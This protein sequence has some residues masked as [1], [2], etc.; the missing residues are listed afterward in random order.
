[1]G[2]DDK[3]KH[4]VKDAEGKVKEAMGKMK[5]DPDLETEGRAKQAEADLGQAGEKVKDAFKN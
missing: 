5:N 4:A 2:I 1:M 3:I